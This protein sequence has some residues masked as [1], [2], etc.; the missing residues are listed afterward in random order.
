MSWNILADI[1]ADPQ[2][3]HPHVHHLLDWK[4]TRQYKIMKH[5][6]HYKPDIL[7]LQEVSEPMYHD[8]QKNHKLQSI[9]HMSN[10]HT[11]QSHHWKQESVKKSI[12]NGQLT[13][14][15]PNIWQIKNQTQLPL[16]KNGNEMSMVLLQHIH[17]TKKTLLVF[18]IHLEDEKKKIRM[19]QINSIQKWIHLCTPY[20][21]HILI[22]GDWNENVLVSSHFLSN[23][24]WWMRHG[25]NMQPYFNTSN[26]NK[27]IGSD[28]CSQLPNGWIDFI[29]I[30]HAKIQYIKILLSSSSSSSS[31]QCQKKTLKQ[32]G[33]DHH[34]III[35][36]L[37]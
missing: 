16:A 30:S 1:W 33:T 20:V 31:F 14:W 11:H 23:Q 7:C 21:D 19:K 10:L 8:L 29:F 3:Y 35:K 24:K 32:L 27:T 13:L 4:N 5:I 28:W 37:L 25:F 6:Q 2:Y 9:Y 22:A 26:Y 17:Y 36:V 18:N 12:P 15:N 34:P